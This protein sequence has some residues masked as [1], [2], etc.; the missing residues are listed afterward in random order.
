MDTAALTATQRVAEVMDR[1]TSLAKV[2]DIIA[3]APLGEV[4]GKAIAGTMNKQQ[5][6]PR[7]N[8][9]LRGR[10]L[11]ISR[12]TSERRHISTEIALIF[13]SDGTLW[14]QR[15]DVREHHTRSDYRYE[16]LEHTVRPG[17]DEP[18]L[19]SLLQTKR[20]GPLLT[21]EVIRAHDVIL[22]AAIATREQALI[23]LYAQRTVPRMLAAIQA[24]PR[25]LPPR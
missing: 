15:V 7:Y 8:R 1:V 14:Y 24:L 20:I 2:A 25:A 22:E 19:W 11:A 9:R 5:F 21:A 16:V 6:M 17:V 10:L 13:V 18:F 12:S 23:R 4:L 3:T